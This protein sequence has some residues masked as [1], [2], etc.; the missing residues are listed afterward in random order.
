MRITI[1]LNEQEAR[2]F[3][4]SQGQES[5]VV[6]GTAEGSQPQ[7]IPTF[8]GGAPAEELLAG[9]Q[10]ASESAASTGNGTGPTNAGEPGSWLGIPIGEETYH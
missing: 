5:S 4:I 9:I 2:S 7:E 3:T 1:E 8:D 10:A 6:E